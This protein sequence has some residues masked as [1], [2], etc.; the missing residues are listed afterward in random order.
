MS[1]LVVK[2]QQIESIKAGPNADLL[3]IAQVSGWECVVKKDFWH[4]GDRCIY[5][6]TDTILPAKW[7]DYFDVT[8]VAMSDSG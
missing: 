4:V 8:C 3:Q 2:V 6:P 1:S 5:F 7:T